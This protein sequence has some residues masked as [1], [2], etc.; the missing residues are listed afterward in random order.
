VPGEGVAALPVVV[1]LLGRSMFCCPLGAGSPKVG[2]DGRRGGM[3]RCVAL[4][5]HGY[6]GGALG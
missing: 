2:R 4:L 3:K 5:W 6:R 1:V